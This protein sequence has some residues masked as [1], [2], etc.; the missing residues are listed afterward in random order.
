MQT[1]KMK[2]V[3]KILEDAVYTGKGHDSCEMGENIPKLIR[4]VEKEIR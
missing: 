3:I 1:T 4:Q 2:N